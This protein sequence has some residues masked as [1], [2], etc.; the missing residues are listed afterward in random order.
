MTAFTERYGAAS[1]EKRS[2]L[3]VGLDPALPDQRPTQTVPARYLEAADANEARLT[4]CL[5]L[6]ARTQAFCCAYKPNQQYLAGFTAD[7]HRALTTAIAAAGALS[8]LDYKLNDI[9]DTI[10]AA[11]Y[12][13]YRWGYDAVTF[14][15]LLGNLHATVERAHCLQPPI[16]VIVLTLTSNQE[17]P[18]YQKDAQRHGQALY[19][20][21][22][23][24]V[25][26][27]HADGCVVGA[28]GHITTTELTQIRGIVGDAPVFLVPGVGT[29]RGDPFKVIHACGPNLLINVGRAIIY[30]PDP[31]ARAKQYNRLFNDAQSGS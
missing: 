15:P 3:C 27:S 25:K 29:Q 7:D 23:E 20:A 5:D 28:T 8:I 14:N 10:D 31:G 16:G 1:R 12:H 24:D 19:L 2:I 18:H 11:L 30:A 21:I 13:I 22:A 4:F 6:I 9:G 17:A 26:T